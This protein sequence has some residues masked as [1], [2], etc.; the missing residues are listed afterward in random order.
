MRPD[1]HRWR[2]V[3]A[4]FEFSGELRQNLLFCAALAMASAP[5]SG[6]RGL[7]PLQEG[8]RTQIAK[9]PDFLGV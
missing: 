7:R 2:K 3:A 5:I 4:G 9:S 6:Q 1:V 8:H